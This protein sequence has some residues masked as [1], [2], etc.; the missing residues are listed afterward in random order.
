MEPG[1]DGAMMERD[2]VQHHVPEPGGT[3]AQE[4][5]GTQS[6]TQA[7]QSRLGTYQESPNIGK[8]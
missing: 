4:G 3:E 7:M 8:P 6:G 2:A 1:G 5:N